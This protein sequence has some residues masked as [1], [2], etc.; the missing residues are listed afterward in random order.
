MI[1]VRGPKM[2]GR[3]S[4]L[5]RVF[6][7]SGLGALLSGRDNLEPTSWPA[8]SWLVS[9]VGRALHRYRRGHGFKSRTGLNFF[10]ALFHYCLSSANYCEDHFHS[11]QR[12]CNLPYILTCHGSEIKRLIDGSEVDTDLLGDRYV[13]FLGQTHGGLCGISTNSYKKLVEFVCYGFQIFWRNLPR[14]DFEKES[15]IHYLPEN[16][17]FSD[18]I[19]PL[20]RCGFSQFQVGFS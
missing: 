4:L 2:K 9:S 18:A 14:L 8:P 10:Q 12:Q 19:S 17:D 20:R 1:S 3:K 5:M 11:L 6:I 7:I 13:V 15:A 16:R